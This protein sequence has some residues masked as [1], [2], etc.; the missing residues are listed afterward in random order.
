MSSPQYGIVSN[1]NVCKLIEFAVISYETLFH[2]KEIRSK[3]V[4]KKKKNIF[5]FL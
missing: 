4:R 1:I 5:C 2:Q 3:A